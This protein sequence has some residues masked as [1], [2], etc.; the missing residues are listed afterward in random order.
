MSV[1]GSL[2]DAPREEP[3]AEGLGWLT[4]LLT[5]SIA[6]TVA[7]A[8][9][10]LLGFLLLTGQ[11][12]VRRS[13]RVVLGAFLLFGTPMVVAGL[14]Q[15]AVADSTHDTAPPVTAADQQPAR[16]DLPPAD[17]DPY[18]GASLRRD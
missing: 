4:A 5:G 1:Q 12:D 11:I 13:G 9:F 2:L 3:L 18:A 10:A 8:G 7:V 14:M 6:I 16:E 17:Y 15:L